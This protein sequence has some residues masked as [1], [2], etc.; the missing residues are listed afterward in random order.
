[1]RCTDTHNLGIGSEIPLNLGIGSE[2][3]LN[4]GIG[5][6]SGHLT[7]ANPALLHY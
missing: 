2:I 6:E 3:P 1:M 5:S 7:D 4:L